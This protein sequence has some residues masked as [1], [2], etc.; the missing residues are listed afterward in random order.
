MF[1]VIPS[2]ALASSRSGHDLARRGLV[3]LGATLALYGCASEATPPGT[4]IL[5]EDTRG[6]VPAELHEPSGDTPHHTSKHPVH[7]GAGEL[8]IELDTVAAPGGGHYILAIGVVVN[9]AAG[10]TVTASAPGAPVNLGTETAPLHTRRLQIAVHK[11]SW[12]STTGGTTSY[13]V[14]GDGTVE[15]L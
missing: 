15:A 3:A 4:K 8:Q 12:G 1:T 5:V 9:D 7:A 2:R 11:K 14:R 13:R 6:D 10:Y